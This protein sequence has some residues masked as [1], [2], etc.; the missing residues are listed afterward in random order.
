[1]AAL[2]NGYNGLA[3]SSGMAAI[4]GI[5]QLLNH[6][7]HIIASA[8]IYGGTYRL[9]H[10]VL[11]KFNITTTL[12]DTRDLEAVA[13]AF[14]PNTRLLWVESIGNPRM[15]VSPIDSLAELVKRKNCLLGVDNTFASP[16]ICRPLL[17]G[18][19]I[20][21]HSATKYLGGHSDLL[22]GVVVAKSQEIYDELYFYQNAIGSVMSP[23]DSFLCH[24]GIKTLYVRIK[25]Q[26]ASAK[27]V[28]DFLLQHPKVEQVFYPGVASHPDHRTARNQFQEGFGGILS[29]QLKSNRIED[30]EV[31]S[32]STKLF[33]R[34]VS[35]GAVES[36]IEQPATMSHASYDSFARKKWGISDGLIRLSIGLED[37]EDLICDLA[38]ALD[39]IYSSEKEEPIAYSQAMV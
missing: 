2:E 35:V 24:R 18:A 28:A 11:S 34:A 1:M 27:K 26:S 30:G 7:D 39:A 5:C 25:Q 31:L 32:K 29:F 12:V 22:G 21:M 4:H 37:S 38:N 20:V 23:F 3:Y 13:R 8:D 16:A 19:D 15:T 17:L 9:F 10:K 14:R 36:L 33:A 6:G